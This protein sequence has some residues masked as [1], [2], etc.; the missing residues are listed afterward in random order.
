MLQEM[1]RDPE[2]EVIA[3]TAPADLARGLA[4]DGAAVVMSQEALTPR[5]LDVVAGH[6]AAQA[7]WSELP[8]VLLLDRDHQNGAV[9]TRLRTRL[10]G[11]KLT[12]LQRPVRA[13]ELLTAVQTALRARRRQ[14]QLRDHMIRQEELQRELNHRVKN[15]L[16]NVIAIYHMTMRQ[17]TSLHDFAAGFE[18]RLSAL[19]RVH[20][21]A[22]DAGEPRALGEI[23]ELVLAPYLSAITRRV[24]IDGPP[25]CVTPQS[26]V[27]LALC[28]HELATNAAK[29]GAFSGPHG[30]VRLAWTPEAGA[31]PGLRVLW[32]ETGGPPV[33]PP[34]RS[35]YGTSFVRSV[36]GGMGGAIRLEFKPEGFVCEMSLPP[37]I[38]TRPDPEGTRTDPLGEVA[39][40]DP[41][42]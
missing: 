2:T 14:L 16:A 23:A 27:T 10:P 38:F 28:F 42:F 5:M 36:I 26:S 33:V 17:S 19:D 22:V 6:L 9:L 25:V 29:Y 39:K 41:D 12:V 40:N 1:L 24:V 21:A 34:A 3:C 18:G 4:T 35:G 30:T 11:S 32:T 7:D 13:L 20:S 15:V 8:L 37:E 31:P